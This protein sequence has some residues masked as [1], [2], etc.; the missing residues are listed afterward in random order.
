MLNGGLVKRMNRT[1]IKEYLK[2]TDE[3][4][5]KLSGEDKDTFQWVLFGYNE[6]A[7]LLNEKKQENQQLKERIDKAIEI[8]K[9][10][11]SK[12]SKE[13]IKIL[14]GEDDE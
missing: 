2:R 13:T 12:C 10:C 6:C 1:E 14:K 7:R 5:L 9:I 11:N 4:E 8:L 3:L